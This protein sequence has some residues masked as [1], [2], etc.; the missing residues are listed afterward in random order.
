MVYCKDS[1]NEQSFTNDPDVTIISKYRFPAQIDYNKCREEIAG[2]LQEFWFK[3]YFIC[4]IYD[5]YTNNTEYNI[6]TTTIQMGFRR[7]S[8]DLFESVKEFCNRW[9]KREHA[10]SNVS[11]TWKLIIL[12]IIDSRNSFLL[13]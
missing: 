12:K 13:Q 5:K 9:C 4:I 7:K 1:R 6:N 8:N 2:S 3:L 11:N 10:E